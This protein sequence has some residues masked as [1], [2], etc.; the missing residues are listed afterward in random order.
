MQ[1]ISRGLLG[2]G[3]ME[4]RN[5]D[6]VRTARA[7]GLTE[8]QILL[9]HSLKGGLLPVVSYMGP[10]LAGIIS[11][12]LVTETIF[13][14]PGLGKYF[15]QSAVNRDYT[16][17]MGTAL[18]YFALIFIANFLVDIAYALLDPRVKYE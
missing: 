2:G 17:V 5:Q 16:M 7:K 13:N 9:K 8:G 18:L 10:A 12:A 6:F 1:R 11:G 14:I 3:F 4:V 15:I